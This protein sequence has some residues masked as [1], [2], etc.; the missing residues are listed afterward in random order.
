MGKRKKGRWK[1]NYCHEGRVR[2]EIIANEAYLDDDG[3]K[4][5]WGRK[6]RSAHWL[7]QWNNDDPH[8]HEK[9]WKRKRKKQ[10]R[11]RSN[12]EKHTIELEHKFHTEWDVMEWFDDHD[13][14]FRLEK[15]SEH[16]TVTFTGRWQKVFDYYKP[17]VDEKG[18]SRMRVS[19]KNEWV[20]YDKPKIV[21]RSRTVGWILTWW[22][23][24]NIGIDYVLQSCRWHPYSFH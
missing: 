9:S 2:Q 4:Q 21:N 18:I 8:N 20:E 12:M 3:I 11:N 10:C 14:P 23:N 5:K 13:I 6:K 15:I 17:Y 7:N 1:Y 22:S 19:C 24:K 16:Y